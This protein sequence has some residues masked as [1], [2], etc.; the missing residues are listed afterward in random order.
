[1]DASRLRFRWWYLLVLLPILVYVGARWYVGYRIEGAIAAANTQGNS[2]KLDRYS[3]GFFPAELTVYDL[4][5]DQRGAALEGTATLAYGKVS[6]VSLWSLIGSGPIAIEAIAL[7]GMDAELTR[8]QQQKSGKTALTL[9]VAEL[10]LDSIF[11]T[12]KDVPNARRLAL[13][14]LDLTLLPLRFPFAAPSIERLT[15]EGDTV[16]FEDDGL[17]AE[18]VATDISFSKMTE[19]VTIADL[20]ARRGGDTDLRVR[21]I[22]LSGVNAGD[23]EGTFLLDTLHVEQVGGGAR[24]QSNSAEEAA[25]VELDRAAKRDPYP[26]RFT[27]L[28]LPD[29]DVTVDG[30][31]GTVSYTGAVTAGEVTFDDS[32][33]V[34]RATVGATR[35]SFRNTEGLVIAAAGL[36]LEQREL[37]LP[38]KTNVQ[39][40]STLRV[41]SLRIDRSETNL[42]ATALIYG[43]EEG[44]LTVGPIAFTQG[45]IQGKVSGVRLP[46][47]DRD[48]AL[49]TGVLP[50][51]KVLLSDLAATVRNKDGGSYQVVLPETTLIDVVI[52]KGV[53][54]ARLT[55][56]DASVR[57]RGANGKEDLIA[58]G[59]YV[60]QY[61]IA[62]PLEVARL[63]PVKLQ[64]GGVS[65][66]GAS[67]PVDYHFTTIAYDSRVGTLTVD[68][69]RRSNRYAP[70]EMFREEIDKSWLGFGIDALKAT[71]IDHAALLRGE[72]VVVDSVSAKDFRVAVVEDISLDRPPKDKLMPIEALRRIGPRIQLRRAAF[73]STDIS[74]GVVD[75]VLQPKTIHFR[76][77]TIRIEGLDTK[78]SL[79]DSTYLSL[80]ARFEGSTPVHAGFALARDSSGRNYAIEGRLG[81]YDLSGINPLMEVAADAIVESGV[82]DEMTYRGRLQDEVLTGDMSLRY[83]D[84]DLKLV[85]SGAF[86]KNLMSGLVMKKANVAGEDFR[87][88][89]MY[90]EH[91]R[92]R[93]FMNAYW[94]GLVSG[95]K[96]SALS[97]IV[98]QKELE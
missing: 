53:Q 3:F 90:H 82:I 75:T 64:A 45:N 97:D 37:Q 52:D 88:G 76:E 69:L 5:F 25:A 7:R 47:I 2:L 39:G 43:S 65:L 33:S 78:Y 28:E 73:L 34:G 70:D 54:A 62:T 59:V 86:L 8:T 15:V 14:N 77:G 27:V 35:A 22:R 85:G 61:D 11:L 58:R 44:T 91:T 93:S 1:M 81:T 80:D 19:A 20:R 30:D 74:Y 24:V 18:V 89:R 50:L 12:V 51:P 26:I 46:Q 71:G 66:Y 29:I 95:M 32:L 10:Q 21:G 41:N 57:R 98:L 56:S 72:T 6:G 31:F 42:A 13:R 23:L 87:A 92:D 94:K 79:T 40:A 55:L 4:Q 96:S 9:E 63:G 17:G 67:E 49:A 16:R 83:H 84:L 68:S 48:R 36:T 38:L 60:T